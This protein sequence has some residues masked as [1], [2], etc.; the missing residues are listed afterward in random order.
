MTK[1][2]LKHEDKKLKFSKFLGRLVGDGLFVAPAVETA[3]THSGKVQTD[4]LNAR[5]F[6]I[7]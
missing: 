1:R 4:E 2:Y 3:I 7:Y 6:M 5:Q